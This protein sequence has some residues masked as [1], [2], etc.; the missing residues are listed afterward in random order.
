MKKTLYALSLFLFLPFVGPWEGGSQL[1][2]G[3]PAGGVFAAPESLLAA[4]VTAPASLQAV[5]GD[6]ADLDVRDAQNR[7]V[8]SLKAHDDIIA[9]FLANLFDLTVTALPHSVAQEHAYLES[10]SLLFLKSF[11]APLSIAFGTLETAFTSHKKRFVHNVHNLW[12]SF[13][14]GISLACALTLV[15]SRDNSPQLVPIRC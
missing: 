14:V 7:P 2:V 5:A 8:N 1:N 6:F 13:A 11:F 10:L 12:I 9:L 15:L 3:K 4:G